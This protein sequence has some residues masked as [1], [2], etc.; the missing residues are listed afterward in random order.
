MPK[1]KGKSGQNFKEKPPVE[2]YTEPLRPAPEAV[3][4]VNNADVA[5]EKLTR[6]QNG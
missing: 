3:K 4:G 5:L 6:G 1:K 2:F